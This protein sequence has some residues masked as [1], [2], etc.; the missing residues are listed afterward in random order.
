MARKPEIPRI[1]EAE[2]H[3][4][5]VV[6]ERAPVTAQEVA[7]ALEGARDWSARTVKT[8]LAR[9]VKK[10]A[11]EFEVDGKRYLYSPLVTREQGLAAEGR[12][13]MARLRGEPVSPFL[14]WFVENSRMDAAE[15]DELRRLLDEK[16]AGR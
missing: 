12:S 9:L 15:I 10:G 5:A 6:W 7:E 8:L 4:M 2:W 11:L 3:V 14:A 16:E 1:T 13:L